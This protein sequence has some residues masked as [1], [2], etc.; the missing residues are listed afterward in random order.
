MTNGS[1]SP[2]QLLTVA[3]TASLVGISERTVRRM[4]DDGRMPKPIRM[5][6][7]LCRWKRTDLEAWLADGCRPVRT[8]GRSS[9]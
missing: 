9:R 7:R 2:A 6:T 8:G 1:S 3:E 4:A 5:G